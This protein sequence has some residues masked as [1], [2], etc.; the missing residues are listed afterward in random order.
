MQETQETWV[1]SL[2]W[3][4]P[5]RRKWQAHSSIL[6][7]EIPWTEE[8]GGVQSMGLQSQTRL[9]MHTQAWEGSVPWERPLCPIYRRHPLVIYLCVRGCVLSHFIQAWLFAALWTVAHPLGSSAHGSL[10]A[11]MLSG[12]PLPPPGDLADP[13]KNLHLSCLLNLQAGSL[14]LVPPGKPCTGNRI[15]SSFPITLGPKPRSFHSRL[16]VPLMFPCSLQL[17]GQCL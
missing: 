11:R 7:W 14:P 8:P 9:S 10:Q 4:D 17:S 6:A 2:G 5:W 12:L 16:R 15:P 13:G 1:R 3:E